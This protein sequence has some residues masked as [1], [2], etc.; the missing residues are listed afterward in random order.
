MAGF[1]VHEATKLVVSADGDVHLLEQPAN[2]VGED[3]F[4]LCI[5]DEF[6][7]RPD[8]TRPPFVQYVGVTKKRY[9]ETNLCHV[10][11]KI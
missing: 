7:V 6:H 1:E 3:M 10:V 11:L 8:L 9:S 2:K 4:Y 5:S